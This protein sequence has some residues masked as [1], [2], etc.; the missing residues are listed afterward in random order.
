ML[1]GPLPLAGVPD[2][3]VARSALVEGVDGDWR[4]PRD[5]SGRTKLT[6]VTLAA[7]GAVGSAGPAADA[8]IVAERLN[9]FLYDSTT[10]RWPSIL[11]RLGEDAWTTAVALCLAG[12]VTIDCDVID[13]TR[14]G[15][16]RKWQ[17]TE[18][19]RQVAEERAGRSDDARR[20]AHFELDAV[21]LSGPWVDVW[22]NGAARAGL[23]TRSVDDGLIERSVRIVAELPYLAG[24]D[25]VT[26]A[27]LA[28]RLGGK[29]GAHALDDGHRLSAL[30]L[31]AAAA[32]IG[33]PPPTSST[34]RRQV[35]AAVG[36][37]TDT[38]SATVIVSNLRP[39][40]DYG[41]WLRERADGG[42]VCYINA[43]DVA[44][45][46]LAPAAG[47]VVLVC[48]NP[49]VLEA[50]I[51]AGVD[52]TMLCTQ[53]IPTRVAVDLIGDFVSRHVDVRYRGDFDWPGVTFANR[54]VTQTGA[55]TWLFDT[56][57][58]SSEAAVGEDAVPLAGRRVDAVWDGHLASEMARHRVAIHE[59]QLLERLIAFAAALARSGSH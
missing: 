23:L 42:H 18:A 4:L 27:T 10:R 45:G 40:S 41:R 57:T 19:A 46:S 48:E 33:E 37:T 47:T 26:R 22:L 51:N 32:L 14:L 2:G 7:D 21:G 54:I 17:L 29:H 56:T 55:G 11:K 25:P 8:V 49:Q 53:G 52:T 5:R 20:R 43:R 31:R 13:G 44:G 59:E 58:Y 9:G 1:S 12:V 28:A 16:P 24:G 38:I 35:W 50:C 6:V 34:A 36:V 3:L 39:V 30:V 15:R